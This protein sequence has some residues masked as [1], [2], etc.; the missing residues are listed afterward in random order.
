R[1]VRRARPRSPGERQRAW[2]KGRER[3]LR[4]ARPRGLRGDRVGTRRLRLDRRRSG[5]ARNA[6]RRRRRTGECV[7]GARERRS[8]RRDRTKCGFRRARLGN[9]SRRERGVGVTQVHNAVVCRESGDA[10]ARAFTRDSRSF[11]RRGADAD[12]TE[13]RAHAVTTVGGTR[14]E[15]VTLQPAMPPAGAS[16]ARSGALLAAA[17]GVGI[18]LNYAFL[19]AAARILGSDRYGSLGALLGLL[20]VVLIPAGAVQMAVS[21]EVSRLLAAGKSDEADAF[22]RGTLRLAVLA[23]VPLVV[24]ALALA[25][26]LAHL[27][28]IHSAEV[29]ALAEFA[30][31]TSLVFPAAMG[32]LQG[33]QRFHALAVLYVFP[34]LVRLVLLAIVAAAGFRLGGA[35]FATVVAAIAAAVLVLALI[36]HSFQR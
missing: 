17:S 20:A 15:E 23:T 33:R 24:V 26:P 36:R 9:A 25:V 27:L 34:F 2:R 5:R 10:H 32:V 29:V 7:D 22:A 21:R 1:R 30:F 6:E 13:S 28:H 3:D 18:V 16:G 19:L 8:E 4:G 12:T 14:V 35:V 31:I 11:L